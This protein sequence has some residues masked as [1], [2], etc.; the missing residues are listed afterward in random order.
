ML[1]KCVQSTTPSSGITTPSRTSSSST[2]AASLQTSSATRWWRRWRRAILLGSSGCSDLRG[3]GVRR[4][5]RLRTRT[6]GPFSTSASPPALCTSRTERRELRPTS[7][8]PSTTRCCRSCSRAAQTGESRWTSS[9][10]T[11]SPRLSA[12]GRRRW[13]SRSR[14]SSCHR[15]CKRSSVAALFG[16]RARF[17]LGTLWRGRH[18]QA[19]AYR[20]H[21][22]S[23]VGHV[24]GCA[25]HNCFSVKC[26]QS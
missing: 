21:W 23:S 2:D 10:T 8:W 11:C 20:V 1:I 24:R 19:E 25:F 5:P 3:M 18:L 22:L 6:A 17:L 13:R 12:A 26:A 15:R 16:A 14:P 7:R 9:A 4:W